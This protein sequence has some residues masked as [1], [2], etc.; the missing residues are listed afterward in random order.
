M[1][2]RSRSCAMPSCVCA[3]PWDRRSW[4]VQQDPAVRGAVQICTAPAVEASYDHG[5]LRLAGELKTVSIE[6]QP[7][8][9]RG[10]AW[11]IWSLHGRPQLGNTG[12]LQKLPLRRHKLR[13]IDHFHQLTLAKGSKHGTPEAQLNG[14]AR[15]WPATRIMIGIPLQAHVRSCHCGRPC[16][17]TRKAGG[18]VG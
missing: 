3:M 11:N 9:N 8:C 18:S 13:H 14:A 1:S 12:A 5:G 4:P 17:T 6:L 7:S 2:L 15:Q 10:V 16:L